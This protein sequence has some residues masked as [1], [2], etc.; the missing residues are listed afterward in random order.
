MSLAF[1][2]RI[3][4]ATGPADINKQWVCWVYGD[5]GV[6][7]V[8]HCGR[9]GCIAAIETGKLGATY[10]GH[11]RRRCA[12]GATWDLDGPA[13]FSACD[14]RVARCMLRLSAGLRG[15]TRAPGEFSLAVGCSVLRIAYADRIGTART[16]IGTILQERVTCQTGWLHALVRQLGS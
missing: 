7:R 5:H 3:A 8:A 2:S 4:S 10:R 9:L 11:E 6:M 12:S 1:L 13:R 15:Q 14:R 16:S